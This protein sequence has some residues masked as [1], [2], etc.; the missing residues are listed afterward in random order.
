MHINYFGDQLLFTGFAV[1]TG[2][3]W[4]IPVL[5]LMLAGFLFFNIPELDRHLRAHYGDEFEAYARETRSLFHFCIDSDSPRVSPCSA[6]DPQGSFPYAYFVDRT[7][8]FPVWNGSLIIFI[9]PLG[10]VDFGLPWA[11]RSSSS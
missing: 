7:R 11:C 10:G 8:Q 6:S 3:A 9:L 2:F 5:L 1:I 4:T